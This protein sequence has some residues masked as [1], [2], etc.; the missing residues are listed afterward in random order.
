MSIHVWQYERRDD[1]DREALGKGAL[2]LTQ[3]IK[4]ADGVRSSK[5][6]WVNADTVVVLTD[7][8]SSFSDAPPTAD[9]ARALFALSDLARQTR[10]EQWIDPGTGERTYR[11]AG[12]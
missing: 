11:D 10:D 4:A 1:A 9:A 8:E 3:A 5:F 12:R 7:G 2:A 6:Y